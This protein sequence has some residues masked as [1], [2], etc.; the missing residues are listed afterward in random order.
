MKNFKKFITEKKDN[1]VVYIV[2]FEDG[3][4]FNFFYNKDEADAICKQLNSEVES[5]NA[6]VIE[7]PL[8]EI[9]KK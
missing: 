4:M 9:I 2:Q 6:R 5:N 7:T 3:T 8:S 1:E